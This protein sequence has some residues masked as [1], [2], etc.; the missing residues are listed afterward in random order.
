[1]NDKEKYQKLLVGPIER[2]DQMTESS[3]E[4]DRLLPGPA[5]LL[6]QDVVAGENLEPA[7]LLT[8]CPICDMIHII[9]FIPGK[10]L[11]I[12]MTSGFVT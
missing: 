3:P 8:I 7:L 11:G 12:D 9:L 2:F 10:L 5:L 6:C 4:P 1:M